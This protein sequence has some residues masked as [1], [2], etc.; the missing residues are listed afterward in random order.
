MTT[1]PIRDKVNAYAAA[2]D[3]DRGDLSDDREHM[4]PAAFAALRAVLNACDDLDRHDLMAAA[5]HRI[6]TAITNEFDQFA[7]GAPRT[8][9]RRGNHVTG[10]VHGTAVQAGNID[11]GLRL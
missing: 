1:D 10:T 2:T 3:F 11:G 5:V 9:D 7:D 8:R 4:A 6:R